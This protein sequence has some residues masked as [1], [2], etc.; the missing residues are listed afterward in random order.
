[1]KK[2]GLGDEVE[3]VLTGFKGIATAS[4]EFASGQTRYQIQ[5]PVDKDGKIP[6]CYDI[7]EGNLRILIKG[8]HEPTPAVKTSFKI[9][10]EVEDTISGFRGNIT[11]KQICFN[12][13]I[14]FVVQPKATAK[15]KLPDP[16][17]FF[18]PELK[19]VEKAKVEVKESDRRTGGAMTKSVKW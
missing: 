5:P 4:V 6:D 3:D 2:I 10:D 8:K 14:R 18:A 7:D 12:G 11:G 16:K 19:L 15:G 13:C 9:G 1:M 17:G